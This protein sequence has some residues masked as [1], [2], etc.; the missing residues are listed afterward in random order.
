MW[1]S[2]Q[3][4]R[5][6]RTEPADMASNLGAGWRLASSQQHRDEATGRGVVPPKC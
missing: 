1:V 6:R 5:M 3:W 4:R 2:G